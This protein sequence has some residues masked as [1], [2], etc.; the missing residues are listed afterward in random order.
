VG[1]VDGAVLGERLGISEGFAVGM[2]VVGRLVGIDEGT[3]V[4]L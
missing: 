3:T 1:S 4:G 2:T